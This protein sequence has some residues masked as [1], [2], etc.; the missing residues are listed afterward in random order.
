M[1]ARD[2]DTV[3]LDDRRAGV[4]AAGDRPAIAARG[5][6]VVIPLRRRFVTMATASSDGHE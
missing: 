2:P 5:G 3:A 4:A 1:T 6:R